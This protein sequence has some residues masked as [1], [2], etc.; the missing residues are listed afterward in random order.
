M[1]WRKWPAYKQIPVSNQAA[2]EQTLSQGYRQIAEGEED[3]QAYVV[4]ELDNKVCLTR[5]RESA[6]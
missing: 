2:I 1:Q 3:G 5:S 4:L 6:A